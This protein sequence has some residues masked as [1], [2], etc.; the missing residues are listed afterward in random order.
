MDTLDK[1][2]MFNVRHSFEKPSA[3]DTLAIPLCAMNGSRIAL[4]KSKTIQVPNQD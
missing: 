1:D 4:P 3:M 2:S